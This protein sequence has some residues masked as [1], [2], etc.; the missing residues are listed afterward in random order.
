MF[1]PTAFVETNRRFWWDRLYQA[2]QGA[3]V[4]MLNSILRDRLPV[5]SL[6][7]RAS[8]LKAMQQLVKTLPHDEAMELVDSLVLRLQSADELPQS[9]LSWAQ[10]RELSR[11][12]MTLG[13]HTRTHPV[14][15]NV[16]L[17]TVK[18][19]IRECREDLRREVGILPSIFAYPFGAHDS[20]V[21][22][23]A[24]REGLDVAVTCL[25]GHNEVGRGDPMQL[26]RTNITPRTTLPVFRL[27][28][29]RIGPYI[30]R[31]RH[32]G[33]TQS[34]PRSDTHAGSRPLPHP[35][36][37]SSARE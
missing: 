35:A 31:W 37:V 34:M 21:M 27:R 4:E 2:I 8:T 12:G 6:A 28:M 18:T 1:V 20:A 15:T 33:A 22:E 29:S 13:A 19:E 24:R 25:D 26:C 7:S 30:D 16:P 36:P 23:V 5:H 11:E 9:L 14:L 17:D 3:R 32:R 10:L